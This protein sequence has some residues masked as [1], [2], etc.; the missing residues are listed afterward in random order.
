MGYR[1]KSTKFRNKLGTKQINKYQVTD[2]WL[3]IT[4]ENGMFTL[5]K[6]CRCHLKQVIRLP[7]PIVCHF[8]ISYP[9]I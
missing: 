2:E 1:T 7:S 3:S 6:T 9:L 8:D 4:W 5:K